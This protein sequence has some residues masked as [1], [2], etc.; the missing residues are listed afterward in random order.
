MLRYKPHTLSKAEEKLLAMQAEMS[1]TANHVFRQLTDADLKF[2]MVKNEKGE[3]VELSNATFSTVPALAEARPSAK[4]RFIS[5]T[6]SIKGTKTRWPP[7]WPAR[8]SAMST[9]P[10]PAAIKARSAARCFTTTC[11]HSVYDNLIAAVHKHLPAL[12]RYYDLRRRKM[13]LPDIHHYDTYVPILSEL[14]T[15]AHL[16]SGGQSGRAV[17]WSRW[18]AITAACSRRPEQRL[19]RSLS[20]TRASK[21]ARSRPAPST[22]SRTS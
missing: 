21:A 16:G 11:R 12:Y 22:A 5:I 7:R 19:V 17:R 15:R 6:P 4:R 9:T 13:K 2:G 18:A 3:Q 10:R 20:R 1:E 14:E 8:C